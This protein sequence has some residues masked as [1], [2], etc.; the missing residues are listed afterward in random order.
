[1][2]RRRKREFP[3]MRGYHYDPELAQSAIDWFPKYLKHV[4]GRRYAGKPFVLLPWQEKVIGRLYGTV[5]D[6]GIRQ[7]HYVFVAVP[8]K[9]GKS[10]LGAGVALRQLCADGEEAPEV[11]SAAADRDQAAIVFSVARKMVEQEPRLGRKLKIRESTRQM[12]HAG[13]KGHYK[14]L[15]ADVETKHGLDVS[16]VIFDELHAQ[17]HRKLWDV[18]T[19]ETGAARE[20]PV[21]FV[22]TTAGFDRNSICYE[23]WQRALKVQR[24]QREDP[25]WLPF[26][27]AADEDADWTSERVWQGCNPSW[28][29]IIDPERVAAACK[30]AQESTVDE[31]NFRRFRLNQW[32]AQEMRFLPMRSW[33]AC[34]EGPSY[35]EALTDGYP[36]YGGLDLGQVDD[37]SAFVRCRRTPDDYLDVWLRVWMP[38]ANVD[39]RVRRDHVPYDAWIGDGLM[40]TTRGPVTDYDTIEAA[41]LGYKGQVAELGY[42]PHFAEQMAQH[43]IAAGLPCNTVTQSCITLN[44]AMRELLRLVLAKR[45][46]HNGDKILR[47][48]A[49]NVV[50]IQNARGEIMPNKEKSNEKIDGIT[51]LVNAIDRM[52]RHEAQGPSVYETRGVL[53]F[54]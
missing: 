41:M 48:M 13:N 14:V 29:L 52:M 16:G 31:N 36:I 5:D 7:Y 22:M 21:Y 25:R 26:I 17:P 43:F 9:N 46:R 54:G 27:W 47:W 45:I 40:E 1:M 51:A 10:P 15:S 24:G 30:E 23:V 11:Y 35:E 42:D 8:K 50:T 34:P 6:D 19:Y 12:Y 32:V 3:L 39:R 2:A 28:D 49:D 33:D 4:K 20:Q 18:L 38:D 53:S 44:E 37:L